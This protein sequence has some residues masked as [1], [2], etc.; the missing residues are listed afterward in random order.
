MLLMRCHLIN[1]NVVG[2]PSICTP[3]I[4]CTQ[5]TQLSTFR[6]RVPYLP[7]RSQLRPQTFLNFTVGSQACGVDRPTTS[8]IW[9]M[10]TTNVVYQSWPSFPWL[11]EDVAAA[12]HCHVR[13]P[14]RTQQIGYKPAEMLKYPPKAW[15]VSWDARKSNMWVF[16]A[17]TSFHFEEPLEMSF[18][19]KR[20]IFTDAPQKKT[21]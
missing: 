1:L 12:L 11:R 4:D 6:L 16:D 9:K 21:K 19:S 10:P 20:S 13:D 17:C 3:R 7:R 15:H 2:D 18:A 5:C 8:K 14:A